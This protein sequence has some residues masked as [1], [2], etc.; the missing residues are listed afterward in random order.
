M[1]RRNFFIVFIFFCVVPL[2]VF[3]S[4]FLCDISF[5]NSF[6][7]IDAGMPRKCAV[8]KLYLNVHG[9]GKRIEMCSVILLIRFTKFFFSFNINMFQCFS[10]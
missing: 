3:L 4:A 6:F 9:N 2:R 5:W 7:Q 1:Y 8:C 10:W